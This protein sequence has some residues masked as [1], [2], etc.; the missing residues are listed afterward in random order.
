M[1]QKNFK[2]GIITTG[3]E[4]MSG[5]ISDENSRW[6]SQQLSQN[7][8]TVSFQMSC[9]D[10]ATEIVECMNF[11]ATQC[12]NIIITGGL[13]PTQDDITRDAVAQFYDDSLKFSPSSWQQLIK[14]IGRPE[15]RISETNRQQC[16]FPSKATIL[17]NSVGTAAGF[18]MQGGVNTFVLPGPPRE[19]QLMFNTQVFPVLESSKPKIKTTKLSWTVFGIPESDLAETCSQTFSGLPISLAFRARFPVIELKFTMES[20]KYALYQSVFADLQKSLKNALLSTS[21]GY[22]PTRVFSEKLK[23]YSDVQ[24]IDLATDGKLASWISKCIRQAGH[25]SDSISILSQFEKQKSDFEFVQN[26]YAELSD[27]SLLIL[28]APTHSNSRQ[29]SLLIK[30]S[31]QSHSDSIEVSEQILKRSPELYSIY[32]SYTSLVQ[33]NRIMELLDTNSTDIDPD[34]S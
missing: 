22:D 17:P 10:D 18:Y 25:N 27:A 2:I 15:S 30:S 32:V 5:Q 31:N 6:M 12:G 24:I 34:Q 26:A 28:I 8:F 23:K 33:L 16:F 21:A 13:G 20:E 9:T 3:S 1:N 29:V 7:G 11:L 4:V 19:N 14:Y